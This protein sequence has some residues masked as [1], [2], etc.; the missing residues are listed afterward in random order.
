M[1][2]IFRLLVLMLF[3]FSFTSQAGPLDSMEKALM[4]GPLHKSHAE[5]EDECSTCHKFFSKTKQNKLCLDCHDHENIARDIQG[6]QG[7]HGQIP[8]VNDKECKL[9][10]RE[11]IGRE[12]AIVLLDEQ[13]FDHGQTDFSLHGA[14]RDTSCGT[15]H[16]KDK[17]YHQAPR[18]CIQC[19]KEDDAH[20]GRLGERCQAC[21]GEVR[22]QDFRFDH[23]TTKFKLKGKHKGAACKSC[24]PRQ[25]YQHT[26]KDC[27]SCHKTDDKHRGSYGK[28]CQE[29]HTVAGWSA[30]RFDHDKDT[31]YP[32]EGR[33][34]QVVCVKCHKQDT[35]QAKRKK[36]DTKC[37]ACHRLQD[38]H[39]GLFGKQCKDC[40]SVKGW[41]KVKFNHDK[42]D[43][44]LKGRHKD[45]ACRDCHPGDLYKDKVEK[46][47]FSC[48]RH[49]DVHREQQGK[50]CQDCHN[51]SGWQEKV[52]FDH[53][54]T[55]FPLLGAHNGLACEE[56]HTS[57]SF[58][59]T[60]RECVACH[61]EDDIHRQRLGE[62]CDDCHNISDWKSWQFDHAKQTDFELRG[63]HKGIV[64]QACHRLK[65]SGSMVKGDTDLSSVCY[66]CH[67][68]DD[69]H[70]GEFG[71][72]CQRC[73]SEDDFSDIRM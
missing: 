56:C 18:Q 67:R 48:H 30:Q 20:K 13:T 43:Y 72:H 15:C 57:E 40:H 54:L 37:Y 44:P 24:H 52:F 22:W 25:Q 61:R 41:D 21:H 45:V 58:K 73:H 17:K 49:D 68:D 9:C 32:L 42:T 53:G 55:K 6:K 14:H 47:C 29:C 70:D 27:Y 38:E 39:R 51:P 12:A 33:H 16:K 35:R 10:H 69:A 5:F 66:S 62:A 4:P 65:V 2:T 19:H 46:D 1:Q 26:P 8:G 63:A 71:R 59:D 23:G 60:K 11:H 7:F 28:K 3:L 36:L 34:A 64:C 50:Q 31:D